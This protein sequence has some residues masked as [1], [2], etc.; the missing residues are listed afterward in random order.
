MIR[1]KSITWQVLLDLIGSVESDLVLISPSIH[2]EITDVVLSLLADKKGVHIWV[3]TDNN[4][5]NIRKGYGDID[6]ISR[7]KDKGAEIREAADLKISYLGIDGVGYLMFFESRILSNGPGG[8]NAVILDESASR[9]IE[10]S[11]FENRYAELRNQVNTISDGLDTDKLQNTIESLKSQPPVLPD[12]RREISVYN[13]HFQFV[14]LALDGGSINSTVVA[15]PASAL[16]FR[17]QEIRDRMNTRYKLFEKD[18]T[19]LWEGLNG[20]NQKVGDIREKFLVPCS[21]RKGKSI[22]KNSDKLSF[23]TQ[24]AEL[25][26]LIDKASKDLEQKVENAIGKAFSSLQKELE[27]F[28]S[29]YKLDFFPPGLS[30][31]VYENKVKFEVF[32]ILQKVSLPKAS[33]LVK[34]IKV[35][36]NYYDLTWEDTKSKELIDWFMEKELLTEEFNGELANVKSA[37]EVER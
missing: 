27:D 30:E 8:L 23:E 3:C 7:L 13:N 18:D 28:L 14:E 10:Q 33:S 36:L 19:K 17:N 26:T 32:R 20:V 9:F 5:E 12:L 6:S 35:S 29:R 22:L 34:K 15:I 24:I 4:E 21:V 37:Y 31:E 11:F 2:Q 16:P 25:R 1:L